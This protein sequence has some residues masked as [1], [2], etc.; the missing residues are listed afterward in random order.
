M[1]RE[2]KKKQQQHLQYLLCSPFGH[3]AWLSWSPYTNFTGYN[4]YLSLKNIFHWFFYLLKCI[5]MCLNHV[6][7]IHDDTTGGNDAQWCL[8]ERPEAR[9]WFLC[10]GVGRWMLWAFCCGALSVSLVSLTDG[11]QSYS[12]QKW[13]VIHCPLPQLSLCCSKTH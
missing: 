11:Q 4:N 13:V 12:P 7:V 1:W 6:L 2:T 8:W 3:I 5:R 9:S 10:S